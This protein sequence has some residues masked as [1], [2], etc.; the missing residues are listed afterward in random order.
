VSVAV[1]S[2]LKR[3]S[4]FDG[5]RFAPQHFHESHG[6]TAMQRF[7]LPSTLPNLTHIQRTKHTRIH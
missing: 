3:V 5:F 6:Q 7:P 2:M 1:R 4:M